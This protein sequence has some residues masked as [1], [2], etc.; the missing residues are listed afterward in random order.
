M[1]AKDKLNF[2]YQF[3]EVADAVPTRSYLVYEGKEWTYDEVR[4]I[5]Q[6]YGNWFLSQ[7]IKPR[8]ISTMVY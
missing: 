1:L 2:F 4:I 6:K 5:A 8:G 7:G 3:E